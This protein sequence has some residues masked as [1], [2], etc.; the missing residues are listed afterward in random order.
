MAKLDELKLN[1]SYVKWPITGGCAFGKIL[2]VEN[3]NKI[4]VIETPTGSV[5][6]AEVAS[7]VGISEDDYNDNI[8]ELIKVLNMKTKA[9]E[10]VADNSVALTA[11]I[12]SLKAKIATYETQIAELTKVNSEGLDKI[13]TLETSATEAQS[14]FK[15]TKESLDKVT[16]DFNTLQKSLLASSRLAEIKAVNAVD[17]IDAKEDEAVKILGDMEAKT[18]ATILKAAT[19]AFQKSTSQTVTNLPKSTDQTVTSDPKATD[20]NVTATVKET[21]DGAEK[22]KGVASPVV[23][24]TDTSNASLEKFVDASFNKRNKKNKVALSK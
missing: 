23:N 17:M 16:S 6:K 5:V 8:N 19:V 15:S 20:Q 10:T 22:D 9:N 24:V 18:Y 1:E 14:N 7:L 13:K 21:L 12:D 3:D 11:E 2:S 4:G